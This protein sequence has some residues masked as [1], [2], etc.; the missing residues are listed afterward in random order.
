M[1]LNL[2]KLAIASMEEL[3]KDTTTHVDALISSLDIE[4]DDPFHSSH[5]KRFLEE[6]KNT[7]HASLRKLKIESIKNYEDFTNYPSVCN[8]DLIDQEDIEFEDT[9][10]DVFNLGKMGLEIDGL[11]TPNLEDCLELN[12]EDSTFEDRKFGRREYPKFSCKLPTFEM[13]ESYWIDFFARQTNKSDMNWWEA[14][15]DNI[16]LIHSPYVWSFD[17]SKITSRDDFERVITAYLAMT[18]EIMRRFSNYLEHKIN[19]VNSD[20]EDLLNDI[21]LT[22]NKEGFYNFDDM[23]FKDGFKDEVLQ[24]IGCQ[25]KPLVR[26]ILFGKDNPSGF[27]ANIVLIEVKFESILFTSEKFKEFTKAESNDGGAL[28]YLKT[29]ESF[30]N[31]MNFLNS[32]IEEEYE[33]IATSVEMSAFKNEVDDK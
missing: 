25:S 3:A 12:C 18:S 21:F 4:G 5:F 9:Y 33:L 22:L 23:A 28:K 20:T 27:H 24:T 8:F 6:V 15:N 30:D 7:F 19:H 2:K 13:Y 26:H 32:L 11:I 10:I 17:D 29:Q 31:W 16:C 1:T 14:L